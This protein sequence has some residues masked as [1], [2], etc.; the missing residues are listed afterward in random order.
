MQEQFVFVHEAILESILCGTNE[1]DS[2]KI[3]KEIENLAVVQASGM[4]G[5]EEK[6]KVVGDTLRQCSYI[7]TNRQKIKY[8]QIY[9]N[10]NKMVSNMLRDPFDFSKLVFSLNKYGT[11][12]IKIQKLN[13]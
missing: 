3:R 5:F 8:R 13:K 10:I 7:L 4:T 6:F 2:A 12:M 11:K 1:V 9:C